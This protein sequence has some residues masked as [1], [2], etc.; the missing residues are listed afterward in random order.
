[1]VAKSLFDVVVAL[2]FGAK[3]KSL[4]K[5]SYS[6]FGHSERHQ[7]LKIKTSGLSLR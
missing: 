4:S 1:M 2:F 3:A 7:G 6:L 5:A